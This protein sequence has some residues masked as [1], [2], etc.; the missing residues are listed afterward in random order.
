MPWQCFT[1]SPQEELPSDAPSWKQ[2]EYQ[3]WYHDPDTVIK[4]M[5]NNPDFDGQFDYTPYIQYDKD[6]Q[7]RW[8]NFMSGNYAWR[9]SVRP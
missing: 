1:V 8:K 5:L 7:R 9:K 2:H 6:G 4:N 3:V